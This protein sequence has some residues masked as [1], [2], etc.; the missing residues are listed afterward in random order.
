MPGIFRK[1]VGLQVPD[2]DGELFLTT[3]EEMAEHYIEAVREVQPEGPYRLGGWSMGGLVALEMAR[4]LSEQNQRVES[5]VL[6]DSVAPAAQQRR[7]SDTGD[8][9]MALSFAMDLAGIFGVPVPVSSADVEALDTAEEV[10]A[11]LHERMQAARLVPPDLELSQ[12]M[13][14]FETFRINVRAMDRYSASVF[15]GR[16]VLFKAGERLSTKAEAPDLGWCELAASG[17]EIREVAGNHYSIL[18]EPNVEVLAEGLKEVLDAAR[19]PGGAREKFF[20]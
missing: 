19:A 8:A 17:M 5:L 1:S 20:N 3:I 9:A 10:L 7:L 4:R 13:R 12:I 6:I 15:S 16:L 14:L 18:R 2:R 11:L